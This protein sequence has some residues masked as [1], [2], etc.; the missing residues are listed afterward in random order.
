M[1]R[2]IFAM[3]QSLD[4]YVAAADGALEPAFQPPDDAL[5]RHW[6]EH[7]R[8]LAGALYGRRIYEMLRYWDDDRPEWTALER[9]FAAAWRAHPK[10]VASRST[11]TVGPN[12]AL[13]DRD[14][15]AFVRDLK[16]KIRGDIAVAGPELAAS[17]TAM[18]LIDEYRLY[19]RPFVLGD[20]KPYFAGT[21]PALRLVA[22]DRVGAD[23]VRLTYEPVSPSAS[24]G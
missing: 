24:S 20:G 5:F 4:G 13:V 16:A 3:T 9:D 7:E 23:A 22:S 11:T 19:V 8:G 17:L 10:W 6:T 14:L 15:G 18:D 21:R 2:L 12:A 1:A